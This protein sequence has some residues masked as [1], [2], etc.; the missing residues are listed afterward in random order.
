MRARIPPE[1]KREYQPTVDTLFLWPA[2][3]DSNPRPLESEST[4][5][6]S[7]ATG[8]NIGEMPLLKASF[9]VHHFASLCKRVFAT[10]R[11]F[12]HQP[13]QPR[14]PKTKN[15]RLPTD[16]RL[17]SCRFN[18]SLQRTGNRCIDPVWDRFHACPPV[19]CPSC[20][21]LHSGSGAYKRSHYNECCDWLFP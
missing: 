2:R 16:R 1:R 10:F 4:A 21:N 17:F 13:A 11:K 19:Y 7:F 20:N 14:Q 12:I 5:I 18:S 9:I 8:G 3:R 6:S 15:N